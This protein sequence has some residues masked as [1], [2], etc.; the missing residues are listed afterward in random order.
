MTKF[1]IFLLFSVLSA[2]CYPP[3]TYC[4]NLLERIDE[5]Y[6]RDCCQKERMQLLLHAEDANCFPQGP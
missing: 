5:L 3:P 2:T 4:Q 6:E 1:Q